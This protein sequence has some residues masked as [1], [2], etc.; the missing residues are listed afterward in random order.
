MAVEISVTMGCPLG[1][2]MVTGE[3]VLE[4]EPEDEVLRDY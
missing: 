4:P 3:V 1:T 2:M